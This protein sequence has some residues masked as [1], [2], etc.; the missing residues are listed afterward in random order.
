MSIAFV[1]SISADGGGSTTAHPLAFTSSNTV[2]NFLVVGGR[3]GGSTT[4]TIS[5]SQGNSWSATP[6]VS[7]SQVDDGSILFVFSLP[8]CKAGAN[9]VT[10]TY[11]TSVTSRIW[12]AEYSGLVTATPLDTSTS[13]QSGASTST[14]PSSGASSSPSQAN[15]LVIGALTTGG[16][17]GTISAGSGFTLRE[18]ANASNRAAYED[19]IIS[20]VAAQTATFSLSVADTYNAAVLIYKDAVAGG[21]GSSSKPNFFLLGVG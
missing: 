16:A 9:T 19:K 7:R 11:G 6:D 13:T 12:I 18:A 3:A 14:T 8:N 1:Q 4:I 15:C 20:A 5:D 2:G 10:A 17:G 21:G